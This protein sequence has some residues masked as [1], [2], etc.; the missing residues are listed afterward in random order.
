PNPSVKP[1]RVLAV[2]DDSLVLMNTAAL[3]GDLGHEVV[4]ANSGETAMEAV[5]SMPELDLVITDQAMPRRR[6]VQRAEPIR[7]ARPGLPLIIAT[8]SARGPADAGRHVLRLMKP[9]TQA[10]LA[11][12]VIDAVGGDEPGRSGTRGGG[13]RL[14]G[15]SSLH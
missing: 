1:L 4:C 11:N 8:G 14:A 9:F 10:A 7:E 5:A 12:A 2:D 3:L 13:S 15:G 6:G